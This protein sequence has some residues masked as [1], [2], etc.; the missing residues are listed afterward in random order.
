MESAA[1]GAA[2][3]SV[4]V[5]A[6]AATRRMDVRGVG[7]G[8]ILGEPARA[9]QGGNPRRSPYSTPTRP[10]TPRGAVGRLGRTGE[11]ADAE[12]T[13]RDDRRRA[14]P[15]PGMTVQINLGGPP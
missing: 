6:R 4:S 7:M 11:R 1:A 5:A 13:P 2:A 10:G 15:V 9:A 12:F 14:V 8:A 3:A